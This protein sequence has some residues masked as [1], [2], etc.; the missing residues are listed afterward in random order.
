MG[1]MS[2]FVFCDIQPGAALGWAAVLHLERITDATGEN[3]MH[4]MPRIRLLFVAGAASALAL[5]SVPAGASTLAGG[6]GSHTLPPIPPSASR[7]HVR[8]DA[9][10]CYYGSCYDYVYGQQRSSVTGVSVQMMQA[11]PEI[12][13]NYGGAHSLQEISLQDSVQ[14]QTV[15]IGWTVDRGVNGDTLPH[16]FVYHWVNGGTSCYN[17]CGF[18]QVSTANA[19]GETV[20]A[21]QSAQYAIQFRQGNWWVEYN[22]DWVGYFPESLWNNGFTTA[23]VVSAFGE[24]SES[25]SPSCA[26]M[27]NGLFGTATGS[28]WISDYQ[29]F[30]TS[31]A[32][33]FALAATS[34]AD[35]NYGQATATSYHLGGPGSGHC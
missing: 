35:Y 15:E 14:Q 24:V 4:I 30:G 25:S 11:D 7:A 29:L 23:Q 18:V 22:N 20:T 6:G 32:P 26:D 16:L 2:Q 13:P 34:P 1:C 12:D 28:S 27:G 21:G 10:T 17:G 33:S 8:G 31:S 19:P 9:A 5:L 3:V